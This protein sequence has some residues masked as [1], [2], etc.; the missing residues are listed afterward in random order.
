MPVLCPPL[1]PVL[2]PV[3]RALDDICDRYPL[4]VNPPGTDDGED[5]PGPITEPTQPC[6]VN[7]DSGDIGFPL[8]YRI[9]LGE[10]VGTVEVHWNV[11]GT[12]D[13]F[14]VHYNGEL[15]FDTGYVGPAGQ[16]ADLDERLAFHGLPSEPLVVTAGSGH[17]DFV[18]LTASPSVAYVT[19][20]APGPPG[21]TRWNFT[22]NCPDGIIP[23]V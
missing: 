13:K 21:S 2:R 9:E 20:Y 17:T 3:L 10:A 7:R 16:Q 1:R 22:V 12:P 8:T 6:G 14:L 11:V 19:V 23:P 15:M 18:K 4:I 5:A